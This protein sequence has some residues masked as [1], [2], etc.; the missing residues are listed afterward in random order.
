MVNLGLTELID[1]AGRR[2]VG[3]ACGL[4]EVLRGALLHLRECFAEEVLSSLI[5]GSESCMAVSRRAFEQPKGWG[6][7]G[8]GHG[9]MLDAEFLHPDLPRP[10]QGRQLEIRGT[11]LCEG[12]RSC[13]LQWGRY[14][15]FLAP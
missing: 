15:T 7:P 13:R 1:R 3:R 14:G 4:G 12:S 11:G 6:L 8:G 2:R 10:R 5:F 9:L